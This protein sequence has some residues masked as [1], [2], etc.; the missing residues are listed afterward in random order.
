MWSSRLFWKT[1][2]AHSALIALA[3][4]ICAAIVAGW[5]EEQLIGQVQRRL[6]DAATLLSEDL[7]G[8]DEAESAD[9]LTLA[10]RQTLQDRIA[11]IG[12]LTE[13]RFTLIDQEGRVLADSEQDSLVAV[14]EMDNHLG[15]PEFI[16]ALHDGTGTS[17]R[18]SPTLDVPFLYYAV[19][20]KHNDESVVLV[21]A[22]QPIPSILAEVGSI[23]QLIWLVGLLV[24]LLSL[25]V[26]YW[27]T[28]RTVLPI[29]SLTV[30]AREVAEGVAPK[31]LTEVGA[32]ELET[33]ASA[34]N[35]M[36][37]TLTKREGQLRDNMQRHATVL[38]GMAEGVIAVDDQE[39]ILFANKA[40]GRVFGFDPQ[41][42]EEQTLL[43]VVRDHRLRKVVRQVL[44]TQGPARDHLQWRGGGS[45]LELEIHGTP[46]PGEPCPGVVLVI[47]D[48]TAL[49]K[50]EGV[51]QEF[52]ANVSH[53]LKTPLSSIKAYA[54]TLLSGAINDP[55][56]STQFLT[57]IDE[58]ADRLHSLIQDM[59]GLARIEAGKEQLELRS[60]PLA[61]IVASSLGDYESLAAA[62]HVRLLSEIAEEQ[63]KVV[64]D[65]ESLR[66]V[67]GNLIDNAVKYTPAEGQVSVTAKSLERRVEITVAD[68]GIGIAPEHHERLFERFYRVDRA[69]SRELGGTGL[70]LSIV[71]HLCQAMGGE[72]TVSSEAGKGSEFRVTLPAAGN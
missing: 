34:F 5:Q 35:A 32:G 54:E 33:L 7:A 36:V 66:H 42:A 58:Q 25:L 9:E 44:D 65:E 40:A 18:Q 67:L 27:L 62:K 6:R 2:L 52:V 57:R 16:K 29:Q 63:L 17:R 69:R 24:G 19:A 53:E 8:D 43:E 55:E 37:Q 39:R 11:R 38:A 56:H 13:T 47:D 70:G 31:R 41:G 64:A 3:V 15:R 60:M 51:R 28:R 30:A 71:K 45:P 21:R 61:P 22:A 68:T 59:L 48:V 14:E 50:L 72:V 20:V 49:S 1:F 23:R 4:G 12:K 46:L 26:T 10:D